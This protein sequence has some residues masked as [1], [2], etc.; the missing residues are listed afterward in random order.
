MGQKPGRKAKGSETMIQDLIAILNN[1]KEWDQIAVKVKVTHM[2]QPVTVGTKKFNLCEAV[3]SDNT[4]SI[5]FD[6]WE[7]QIE[8]FSLGSVYNI[9]ALSLR[10]WS[11]SKKLA[12]VKKTTAQLLTD[13]ELFKDITVKTTDGKIGEAGKTAT[14]QIHEFQLIESFDKSLKC[15][16]CLKKVHQQGGSKL[17]KCQRCGTNEGRQMLIQT[18][19]ENKSSNW[20]ARINH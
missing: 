16:K 1:G 4:A 11:A 9:N 10:V 14:V 3:L 7:D 8:K 20:K 6:I 19:T 18:A 13:L 2:K 15:R 12:T 5:P 17:V